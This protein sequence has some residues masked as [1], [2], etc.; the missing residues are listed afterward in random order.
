MPIRDVRSKNSS[1]QQPKPQPLPGSSKNPGVKH[2]GVYQEYDG[3]QSNDPSTTTPL[4][5]TPPP[6]SA[7]GR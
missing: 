4:P 1:G 7:G 5:P 6:S 3:K 2:A